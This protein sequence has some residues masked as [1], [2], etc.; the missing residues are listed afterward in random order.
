ML[1]VFCTLLRYSLVTGA[2]ATGVALFLM[3][4]AES[5]LAAPPPEKPPADLQWPMPAKDYASTHFSELDAIATA[6]AHSLELAW[7]FDIGTRAVA[8]PIVV[9]T[10][11]Y[12]LTPNVLY[13]L[14]LSRASGGNPVRWT[15]ETK[16]SPA[17]RGVA[18]V[19]PVNR[20]VCYADGKVF[21]NTLDG[22]AIAVD[23][24]TGA[25][26]W[27]TQVADIGERLTMA[28]FVIAEKLLV[29]NSGG[30]VGGSGWLKALDAATG[31][32]RWT[33]YTPNRTVTGWIS[34]DP[35]L[36]VIYCPVLGPGSGSPEFKHGENTC[37]I[38]ARDPDTG[39]A[40]WSYQ[41]TLQAGFDCDG[42]NANIL[43]D[44]AMSRHTRRVLLHVERTGYV[45]VLDRTTGHVISST[46][47]VPMTRTGL[48]PAGRDISQSAAYS[49]RTGFLYIPTLV[50][51]P[52]MTEANPGEMLSYL[53]VNAKASPDLERPR[54]QGRI[55][56][57]DPLARRAAWTFMEPSPVGTGVLATAGNVVFYGTMDGQARAVNAQS[58]K[59]LW[60]FKT[61]RAIIGQPMTYLGPGGK[62]YVAV[63]SG[64]EPGQSGGRLLVFSLP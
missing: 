22:Y 38:L 16:L 55:V 63:L 11:M 42:M 43:A 58:G 39:E 45:C 54:S 64:S 47:F 60:T 62:Q 30:G 40:R 61:K 48:H 19:D 18:S 20:G 8:A 29:G 46:P 49:P 9:G 5:A 35:G 41:C 6:N 59:T 50:M 7:S 13:A 51:N 53:G 32:L 44:L 21:M 3:A 27:K 12:L 52:Q 37:S 4:C 33:D 36:H 34:Y 25:E 14:D 15:Y 2:I 17:S 26:I 24:A 10:M 57:W 1:N 56:A 28:P 31:A 23:G